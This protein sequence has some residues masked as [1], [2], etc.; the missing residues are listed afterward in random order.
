MNS[1]LISQSRKKTQP[2]QPPVGSPAALIPTR[3]FSQNAGYTLDIMV[4][5]SY[6]CLFAFEA[7]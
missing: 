6:Y 5:T 3:L 7:T 1:V 2:S 4:M